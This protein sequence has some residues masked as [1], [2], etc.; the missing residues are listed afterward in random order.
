M[1][2][3]KATRAVL[4]DLSKEY[5]LTQG[6]EDIAVIRGA[7]D[8]VFSAWTAPPPKPTREDWID[9]NPAQDRALAVEPIDEAPRGTVLFLHG[10]GWSLGNALCY[11]PLCR[12]LA[13]E[14]GLRVLAPDFPQAPE[15]PYPAALDML[16]EL[17]RWADKRYDGP[18][19]LAGDSAGGTLCAVIATELSTEIKVAGQAL[20]YPV[21]DLRPKARYRSRKRLGS[22]KYFLSEDG[23]LGAAAAYCGEAGDPSSP[24]LSPIVEPQI[25]RLPDTFLLIPELDPLKDE[26]ERYGAALKK[27]GVSVEMFNAR[28]TIHGCVSFCRRIPQGLDGLKSAAS[29]LRTRSG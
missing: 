8:R 21:L 24:R 18:L 23:I 16:V 11:A 25:Q 29:F 7:Y 6:H 20:F 28:N 2:A 14:S 12:L 19:M 3:D 1:G 10:G 26:C 9:I 4:R 27:N 5:A 13:A 22:G 15:A 17:T